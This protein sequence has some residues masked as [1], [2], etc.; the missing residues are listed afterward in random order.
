MEGAKG[1]AFTEFLQLSDSDHDA[2]I[3]AIPLHVVKLRKTETK[4]KHA[5]R[6]LKHREFDG[7]ETSATPQE[8]TADDRETKIKA[9]A[10][11]YE[12][13][14]WKYAKALGWNSTKDVPRDLLEAAKIRAEENRQAAER[15][16]W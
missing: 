15:P 14:D 6:F 5:C 8:A 9:L 10:I 1:E 12:R 13:N 16:G 2:A 4:F 3:K 11:G 7:Y